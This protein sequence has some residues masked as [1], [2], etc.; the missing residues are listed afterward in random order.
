[1]Y[2]GNDIIDY[3]ETI[4]KQI[5]FYILDAVHTLLGE[6]LTFISIYPFL[7]N[8]ACVI[9]HDISLN[10]G[11][12]KEDNFYYKSEAFCTKI[13]FST[14]SSKSKIILSK[15]LSSIGA[16]CI[17]ETTRLNIEDIFLALSI[18][19]NYYPEKILEKYK[20]FIKKYYSFFCFSY[21]MDCLEFQKKSVQTGKVI[22]S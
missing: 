17:D 13:L 20:N 6:L 9:L 12:F 18:T 2:L 19:W 5:D 21:F 15:P 16:F 14:V 22:S 1:M 7:S 11:G 4:G 10:T 3:I 8:N